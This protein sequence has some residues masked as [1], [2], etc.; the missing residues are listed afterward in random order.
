VIRYIKF[1]L[2]KDV[3]WFLAVHGAVKTELE[4]NPRIKRE[5]RKK[6]NFNNINTKSGKNNAGGF[7]GKKE[8]G[9]SDDSDFSDD[10]N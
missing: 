4:E 10:E 9:D 3:E 8:D 1:I 5:E 6:V 2:S 7:V